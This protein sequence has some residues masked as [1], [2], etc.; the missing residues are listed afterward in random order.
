M[1]K[2]TKRMYDIKSELYRKTEQCSICLDSLYSLH[3]VKTKCLHIYHEKCIKKYFGQF[4]TRP[5]P[6]CRTCI[7]EPDLVGI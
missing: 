4:F 6:L 7:C 3:C 1:V 2:L 5:C